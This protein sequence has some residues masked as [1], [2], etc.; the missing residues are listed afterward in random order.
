[1]KVESDCRG[2]DEMLV[3]RIVLYR[4]EYIKYVKYDIKIEILPR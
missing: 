4:V 2:E 3:G 1:M